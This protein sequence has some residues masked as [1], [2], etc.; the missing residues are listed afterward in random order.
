MTTTKSISVAEFRRG[1]DHLFRIINSDYHGCVGA[2]EMENWVRTATRFIAE[3]EALTCSRAKP[4]DLEQQ[5]TV[6]ERAKQ[7]LVD[8]ASRIERY[9]SEAA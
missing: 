8:A 1:V 4:Y 3:T 6:I 2:G 9:K 5:R 7:R